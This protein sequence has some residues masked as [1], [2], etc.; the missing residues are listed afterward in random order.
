MAGI[1]LIAVKNNVLA[2]NCAGKKK[3]IISCRR[4]SVRRI[5]FVKS[6]RKLGE[7]T[8]ISAMDKMLLKAR[9]IL[10]PERYLILGSGLIFWIWN[11]LILTRTLPESISEESVF[12]PGKSFWKRYHEKPGK[13]LSENLGN[14][15][16][17]SGVY[18]LCCQGEK[19]E[20]EPLRKQE[21]GRFIRT[22]NFL[23]YLLW[24]HGK[25]RNLR[26]RRGTESILWRKTQR[27]DPWAGKADLRKRREEFNI[28]SEAAWSNTFEKWGF[29]EEERQKTGYSTAADILE[30]L[31]RSS[32]L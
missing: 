31:A 16:L 14:L 32:L 2:L 11:P 22:L 27:P 21:C 6:W 4:V 23:L 3:Y 8:V 29:R 18:R 9:G 19:T 13:N 5:S 15:C 20:A 28:N 24:F 1:A 25:M 26:K 30:K 17:L 7:A 10:E 12:H